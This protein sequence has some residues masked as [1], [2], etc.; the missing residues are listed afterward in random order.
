[1]VVAGAVVW[2]AAKPLKATP[3]SV[4]Q[5]AAVVVRFLAWFGRSPK[6]P[7]TKQSKCMDRPGASRSCLETFQ[8]V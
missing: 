7:E 4:V 6:L 5:Q 1:M 3:V 8:A 2:A